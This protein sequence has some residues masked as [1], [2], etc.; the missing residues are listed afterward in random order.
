MYLRCFIN[1]YDYESWIVSFFLSEFCY[2]NSIHASTQ[3]FLFL[4]LYNYQVNNFTKTIYLV[5]FLSEIKM[6]DN[7]DHNY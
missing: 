6:I 3:Q 7:F 1:T 2:N 5:H 4:I